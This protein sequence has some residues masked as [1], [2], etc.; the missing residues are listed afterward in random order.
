METPRSG[1]ASMLDDLPRE[2]EEA[3]LA[4]DRSRAFQVI[5]GALSLG[6]P[7]LRLAQMC[8]TPA[9]ERIGRRWES[10]ALALS[11]VYMGG[12]ISEE[13]VESLFPAPEALRG[14][15]P[16]IALA[17]LEDYHALG[18]RGVPRAGP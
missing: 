18:K 15:Q 14:R 7:P 4:M 1:Y 11:Q 16:A 3:L 2:F 9:L 12:R 13:V 6:V 10:G 17:L 8:I 5:E